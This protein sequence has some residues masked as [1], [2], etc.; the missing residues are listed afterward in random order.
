MHLSIIDPAPVEREL[1]ERREIVAKLIEH[2]AAPTKQPG[3]WKSFGS[4]MFFSAVS[5]GT[6]ALFV[7]AGGLAEALIG[8]LFFTP[9]CA[10]MFMGSKSQ[11][12]AARA[13]SGSHASEAEQSEKCSGRLLHDIRKFNDAL[14]VLDRLSDEDRLRAEE[15]LG[16][17][18]KMLI[19]RQAAVTSVFEGVFAPCL[20]HL[21][22]KGE[23]SRSERRLLRD[24]EQVRALAELVPD[25][26]CSAVLS[27]A[28]SP[29]AAQP[30][31]LPDPLDEDW[32]RR[33]AA[34]QAVAESA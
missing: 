11:R 4:A 6:T 27:V 31:A 1:A 34:L 13:L 9:I 24:S 8:G 32:D 22:G 15:A 17:R 2:Q 14:G 23:W 30:A 21:E 28:L 29:L 3:W 25:E 19:D 7:V 16:H 26:L 10:L 33:F 20:A 18:R 5:A 12:R